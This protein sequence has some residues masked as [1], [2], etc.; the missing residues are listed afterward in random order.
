MTIITLEIPD[1]EAQT[2]STFIKEKGGHILAVDNNDDGFTE[3]ELASI[4]QGLKEALMIKNG[5]LKPLSMSD[6]WDE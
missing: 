3:D 6:L 1:S 2:V 5:G 4:K